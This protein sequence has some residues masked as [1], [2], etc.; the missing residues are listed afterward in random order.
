MQVN[1]DPNP[2]K[3]KIQSYNTTGANHSIIVNQISYNHSLLFYNDQLT[4]WRPTRFEDIQ[5]TDFGIILAKRPPI[6]LLGTGA[7]LQIPSMDLLRPLFEQDIGVEFMTT[8][9]AI[10]TYLVLSSEAREVAMGLII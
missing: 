9:A 1:Q 2:S 3:Y 5:V 4:L 10:R 8:E 7:S 6:F